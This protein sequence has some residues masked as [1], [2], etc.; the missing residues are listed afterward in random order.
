[1]S[2][3]RDE[4]RLKFT[5]DAGILS[6]E[7][8][9][10]NHDDDSED[11]NEPTSSGSRSCGSP[12]MGSLAASLR[13]F[14]DSLMR[15]EQAETEMMRARETLRCEEEKRRM[16]MEAEL[17]RMMLA[18]E[19]QIA[20]IVAGKGGLSRKRKRNEGN[21]ENESTI[22]WRKRALLRCLLHCSFSF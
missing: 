16:E 8:T 14:G 19:L 12:P 20:S 17:T 22:S 9:P 18:T 11:S 4:N 7:C 13:L 1:M 6:N 21:N 5:C 2:A 3:I 10:N 15:M